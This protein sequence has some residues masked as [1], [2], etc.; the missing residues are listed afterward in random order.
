MIAL[1]CLKLAMALLFVVYIFIIGMFYGSDMA[2]KY[3]QKS[4]YHRNLLVV[5]DKPCS[6]RRLKMPPNKK[7]LRKINSTKIQLNSTKKKKHLNETLTKKMNLKSIEN[8][9]KQ[10]LNLKIP[11]PPKKLANFRIV[12]VSID[13]R[14]DFHDVPCDV[15]CKWTHGGN[16]MTRAKIL[17]F[18]GKNTI[19]MSMEGSK[20][21]HELSNRG[22]HA[23][24]CTTDHDSDIPMNY[25]VWKWTQYFKP[26]P[27]AEED[28]WLSDI[29]ERK[30]NPKPKPLI[31]FIARNC[32]SLNQR[33]RLVKHFMKE[34]LVHSLSSCLNNYH[35]PNLDKK[36]SK[37]DVQNQYMFY[38]S[39]E[40]ENTNGYIT[41]KLWSAFAAATLPIYYGAPD[42]R[43]KVGML[44]DPKSI[45]D[46]NDFKNLSELTTYVK[47][48]IKNRTAY[49][50][51]MEWR[52]RPL[53]KAFKR[54]WNFAHVHSAC[55]VCRWVAAKRNGLK[56]DKEQQNILHK[57][58]IT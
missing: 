1:T 24:L 29:N 32:K 39:F 34:N 11:I 8:K 18:P 14:H 45:I 55:R 30:L 49:L 3:I 12:K 38:A 50:E 17:D 52:K 22:N 2:G 54:R 47:Y 15:P 37:R 31:A 42:I 25:F 35:E 57:P 16:I 19:L 53:S 27:T 26:K 33:E 9:T 7:I 21:Y 46:Y 44:P 20:H 51:H 28:I 40:N 13:N 23:L 10:L 5:R 36:L 4:E 41:E 58:V 43:K 56:W 6:F 48:L